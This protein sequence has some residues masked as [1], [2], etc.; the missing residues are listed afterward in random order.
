MKLA[1]AL[2]IRAD[3]QNRIE[4]LK[5]LLNCCIRLY[6]GNRLLRT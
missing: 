3:L 1:E 5:S 2:S 6:K 4:Q